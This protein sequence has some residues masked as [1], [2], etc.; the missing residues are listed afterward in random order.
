M[1]T[2][3]W[4]HACVCKYTMGAAGECTYTMG[5]C[6]QAWASASALLHVV[7]DLGQDRAARG[8][9]FSEKLHCRPWA[10]ARRR[11]KQERRGR[12]HVFLLL[13]PLPCI[14]RKAAASCCYY[15]YCWGA[16]KVT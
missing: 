14:I 1:C 13:R 8:L 12:G 16:C 3:L 2:H 6:F 10:E 9:G 5:A 15:C 11:V 7:S 4:D